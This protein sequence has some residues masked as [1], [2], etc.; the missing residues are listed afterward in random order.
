[1]A[2]LSCAAAAVDVNDFAKL[3]VFVPSECLQLYSF[4]LPIVCGMRI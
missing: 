3:Q 2:A 1:M 4:E